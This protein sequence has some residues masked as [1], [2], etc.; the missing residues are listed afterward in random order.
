[1]FGIPFFTRFGEDALLLPP[2][3]IA[4]EP[5]LAAPEGVNRGPAVCG[6]ENGLARPT[7]RRQPLTIL[8]MDVAGYSR[9]VESDDLRTALRVKSMR[10]RLIQPA[11]R[12]HA[13]R[14][15]SVAGDGVM[16][17]FP[18]AAEAVSCAVAI[19]RALNLLQR[20]EP[21]GSRIRLRMGISV[22]SVLMVDGELYGHALNIAAR[23]EALAEPG[24]IYLS[25]S[26]FDQIGSFLPI[27]LDLLGERKMDKMTTSSRVY[28]VDRR[29]L[30]G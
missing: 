12:L 13:G 7:H 20:D 27:G 25:G 24:D 10:R 30:A 17:A 18:A 11:V 26:V 28:R 1:V 8:A 16:A 14:I 15:F 22:G 5:T 6:G 29:H 3:P 23:L 2:D 9:M 4:L 19:Q 21:T